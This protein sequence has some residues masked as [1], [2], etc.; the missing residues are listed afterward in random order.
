L[1]SYLS[2][3]NPSRVYKTRMGSCVSLPENTIVPVKAEPVIVPTREEI[4]EP[5]PKV[6]DTDPEE[7]DDEEEIDLALSFRITFLLLTI[8]LAIFIYLTLRS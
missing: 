2:G 7:D 5:P 6:I 8:F 4:F 3:I 1:Y